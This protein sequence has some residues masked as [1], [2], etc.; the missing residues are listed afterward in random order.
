MSSRSRCD[1]GW[2]WPAPRLHHCPD[3]RAIKV[4]KS[5]A[6]FLE[7]CVTNP[8]NF[9]SLGSPAL[10]PNS[11]VKHKHLRTMR[12]LPLLFL[13]VLPLAAN[14]HLRDVVCLGQHDRTSINRNYLAKHPPLSSHGSIQNVFLAQPLHWSWGRGIP[15]HCVRLL[16]VPQRHGLHIMQ[17]LHHL[18]PARSA[19]SMS[20]PQGVCVLQ[21]QLLSS[22]LWCPFLPKQ[23]GCAIVF[24]ATESEFFLPVFPLCSPYFLELLSLQHVL[25]LAG[26]CSQSTEEN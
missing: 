26:S 25:I 1:Q 10:S 20:G 9:Y 18:G 12:Y 6:L 17:S 11:K 15:W 2:C 13:I 22:T 8:H 16:T 21:R 23:H 5:P 4:N 19:T 3:T 14:A 7:K 24:T